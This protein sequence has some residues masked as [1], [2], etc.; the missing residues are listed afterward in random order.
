MKKILFCLTVFLC[1]SQAFALTGRN[2]RSFVEKIYTPGTGAGVTYSASDTIAMGGYSTLSG[3]P[4]DDSGFA[5][6]WGLSVVDAEGKFQDADILFFNKA[7]VGVSADNAAFAAD[8]AS[9]KDDFVGR[10]RI[11][12]SD[13]V[14]G[15][16][17]QGSTV[18]V[19]TIKD[20]NLPL[21]ASTASKLYAVMVARTGGAFYG[22]NTSIKIKLLFNQE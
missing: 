13:F 15:G 20:I 22:Y 6:L 21:H 9:L 5:T 1:A 2:R 10:I 3:V 11:Q 14:S 8:R 19:A 7:P 18:S 12:N 17:A 4:S 16:T